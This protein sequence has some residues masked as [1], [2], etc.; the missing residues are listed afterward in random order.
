MGRRI[1]IIAE[2]V[3]AE[4]TDLLTAS[5]EV[6]PNTRVWT[7]PE[8]NMVDTIL[9]SSTNIERLKKAIDMGAVWIETNRER[10]CDVWQDV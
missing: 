5:G 3:K 2:L 6:K 8:G 1:T 4:I 7:F 9:H 10:R